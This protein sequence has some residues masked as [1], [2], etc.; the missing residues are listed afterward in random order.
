VVGSWFAGA[1]ALNAGQTGYVMIYN[2]SSTTETVAQAPMPT[3][4]V[5]D[6][7]YVVTKAAQPA[8]GA[9]TAMVRV[10]GGDT[11]ITVTVPASG[12]VGTYTDLSHTYPVNRGD[13]VC[14]RFA[15]GSSSSIPLHNVYFSLRIR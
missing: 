3:A 1:V 12:G 8:T 4:G 13:K 11:G 14:V 10:N 7:L 5:L 9:L 2:F 6:T 15:N